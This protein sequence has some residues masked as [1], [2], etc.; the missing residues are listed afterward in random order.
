MARPIDRAEQKSET[1]HFR[2]T[3]AL[4]A[5][6][7][8][9]ARLS[10]KKLSAECE[11]RLWASMEES[12]AKA[13]PETEELLA[14]IRRNIFEIEQ[15]TG[16]S[17]KKDVATWT[18]VRDMLFWGPINEL[19]ITNTE[20][21]KRLDDSAASRAAIRTEK[22]RIIDVL[23]VL[24]VTASLAPTRPGIVGLLAGF[25]PDTAPRDDVRSAIEGLAGLSAEQKGK[26]L[27][28][29]DRLAELDSQEQD[30]D[31]KRAEIVAPIKEQVEKGRATYERPQLPEA[32]RLAL[33]LLLFETVGPFPAPR[34]PSGMFGAKPSA[35]R[36]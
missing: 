23:A 12:D 24:G 5:K 29:V 33:D 34:L 4:K 31:E 20:L 30:A 19:K 10:G 36:V 15:A 25:Q 32:L 11:E 2:V 28:L 1:L 7:E 17:W 35:G 3:P 6:L 9:E 18:A 16:E 13:S 21:L 14:A 22:Q 26:A 8:A 27:E